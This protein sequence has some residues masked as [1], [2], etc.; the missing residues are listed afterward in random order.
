M[1]ISAKRGRMISSCTD[2]KTSC[3][4]FGPGP[5]KA[6]DSVKFLDDYNTPESYN[7][8]CANLKEDGRCNVWGT[9]MLPSECRSFVCSVRKFSKAELKKIDQV[10]DE[11]VCDCGAKWVYA[12]ESD[13]ERIVYTCELCNDVTTWVRHVSRS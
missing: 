12:D 7:T 2:C 8:R 4:K 1:R 11:M 3:C 9:T 5:W 6:I 10:N 13:S